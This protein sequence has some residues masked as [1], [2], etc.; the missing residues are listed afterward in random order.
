[1]QLRSH[2]YDGVSGN[3]YSQSPSLQTLLKSLHSL[4]AQVSKVTCEKRATDLSQLLYTA[5]HA[6]EFTGCAET[7]ARASPRGAT[8]SFLSPPEALRLSRRQNIWGAAG[9]PKSM[10]NAPVQRH[11]QKGVQKVHQGG[12]K[13][14]K[15]HQKCAKGSKIARKWE[16]KWRPGHLRKQLF[17]ENG[18]MCSRH[19]IYY[20]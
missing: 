11:V 3:H 9:T 12:Q 1:M 17:L 4:C 19:I 2:S 14:A 6:S 7:H 10:K 20:V 8:C 13:C 5:P 15:V 16:V 18:C